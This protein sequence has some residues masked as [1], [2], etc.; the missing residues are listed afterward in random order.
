MGHSDIVIFNPSPTTPSFQETQ[1]R[2][3]KAKEETLRLRQV[4][5]VGAL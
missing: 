5:A 2:G 3:R 1:E 4:D